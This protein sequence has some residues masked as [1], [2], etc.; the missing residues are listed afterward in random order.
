MTDRYARRAV[1]A[2]RSGTTA[3]MV[4]GY[5]FWHVVG[6]YEKD[7]VRNM[8]EA[9]G[10]GVDTVYGLSQSYDT[11]RNLRLAC[12]GDG[13]MIRRLREMRRGRLTWGHFAAAG[14]K[15]RAEDRDGKDVYSMLDISEQTGATIRQMMGHT[16]PDFN[17][18]DQLDRMMSKGVQVAEHLP[19]D[20]PARRDVERAVE[21]LRQA[22]VQAEAEG[23]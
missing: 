5:W 10:I 3:R 4:A 14:R 13:L 21:W 11:Y 18:L 19:E 6:Q 20:A 1:L 12:H 22:R 15:W 7:A 16:A 17:I 2:Y 9:E 8:A 23:L